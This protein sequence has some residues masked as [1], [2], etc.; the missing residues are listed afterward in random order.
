[1][2]RVIINK[3]YKITSKEYKKITSTTKGLN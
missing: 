2:S 1:V 3:E